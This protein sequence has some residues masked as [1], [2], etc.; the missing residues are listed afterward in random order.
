MVVDDAIDDHRIIDTFSDHTWDQGLIIAEV[1]AVCDRRID[2]DEA[3]AIFHV[4]VS[5]PEVVDTLSLY[6]S[7]VITT[8]GSK[9]DDEATHEYA[10]DLMVSFHGQGLD[11]H[12]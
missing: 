9:D 2:L 7:R 6:I 12:H 4:A 3:R 1:V 8:D 10:Y 5:T 11:L